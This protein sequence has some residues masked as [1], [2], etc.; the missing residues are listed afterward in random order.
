MKKILIFYGSYGGGHLSAARSI[1]EY[2]DTNYSDTETCMVD[3]IEYINKALNKVTTKAYSGMAKNAHWI[4]KKVYYGAED[5]AFA[6]VNN[7]TQKLMSIKLNKLL[8]S[9]QPDLIISTHPFSSHMCA[10]L[11]KKKKINSKIATVITDYAPHSQWLM[12]PAYIDYFFVAHDGMKNALLKRGIKESQIKVTGIPLSNRFLA[13]Y[14]K[15]KI[16]SEF[17][18]STNKKTILFFAGGEQGFGKDKIFRMLES[19]IKAF[20]NLQVIAISG[21][22]EKAKKQFDELVSETNSYEN[23]KVLQY[24]NKIPEL[25]SVADLVI[26]KPGGLTTT[27]S[28]ASRSSYYSY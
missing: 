22:N 26:T 17:D 27:E 28:L 13:N 16:L 24:T 15:G 11:K 25:M 1:K 4:W 10:I 3:C 2:I 8:Q 7:E 6:K 14:N 12:H 18:L 19:I 20:P 5:G 23:V 9:Y 21:K